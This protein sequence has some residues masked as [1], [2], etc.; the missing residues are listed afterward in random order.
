[1]VVPRL[2]CHQSFFVSE[3]RRALNL[4]C[5]QIC[6]VQG[7]CYLLNLPLLHWTCGGEFPTFP[8]CQETGPRVPVLPLYLFT[9]F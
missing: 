2:S 5:F 9:V 3:R 6:R 4:T 7:H 8:F 1:M